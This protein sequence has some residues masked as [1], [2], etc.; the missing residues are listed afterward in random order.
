MK[1]YP[2]ADYTKSANFLIRILKCLK[3]NL[4]KLL[5]EHMDSE[6]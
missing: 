2:K 1:I 4:R 5:L 6:P 3:K